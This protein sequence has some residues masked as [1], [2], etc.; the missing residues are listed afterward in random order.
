VLSI[1]HEDSVM[2]PMEGLKKAVEFL[3]EVLITQPRGEAYW[4]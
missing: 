3:R 2:S 4:A 1:E